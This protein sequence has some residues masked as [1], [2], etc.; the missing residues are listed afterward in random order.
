MSSAADSPGKQCENCGAPMHPDDRICAGC[1]HE[2]PAWA[3][4]VARGQKQASRN[5]ALV[6]AVVMVLAAIIAFVIVWSLTESERAASD[7]SPRI[8]GGDPDEAEGPRVVADTR[9][10]TPSGSRPAVFARST[11]D[12]IALLAAAGFEFRPAADG[13]EATVGRWSDAATEDVKS[14]LRVTVL[15]DDG[16]VGEPITVTIDFGDDDA[17]A[18]RA[19]EVLPE[20]PP[21][22]RALEVPDDAARWIATELSRIDKHIQAGNLRSGKQYQRDQ[23]FKGLRTGVA[24]VG[25]DGGDRIMP[26]AVEVFLTTEEDGGE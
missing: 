13:G 17:S 22:F 21:I 24:Y 15:D 23:W 7:Q 25:A 2:D 26:V 9:P 1:G 8:A 3:V 16:A 12:T 4:A 10:P 6:I 19:R 11:E 14:P 20:V 18:R 5:Q